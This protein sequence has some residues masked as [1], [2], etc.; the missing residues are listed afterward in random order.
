VS[1]PWSPP[2]STSEEAADTPGADPAHADLWDLY[3]RGV[4]ANDAGRPRAAQR[5]LG[6]ARARLAGREL[7][8]AGRRLLVRVRLAQALAEFELHGL[9]TAQ[10]TL[11]VAAAEATSLGDAELVALTHSQLAMARGR[12]GDLPGALTE[13][14]HAV[15]LLHRLQPRDQW[16]VH[17]NRGMVRSLLLDVAGARRDFERALAVA[18]AADLTPQ[19]YMAMHNLG[20][21]AYLAGDLPLALG[22]M[23]EADAVPVEV[24]R[25][26]PYLDR[27]RVL[28]EAGLV[29]EA[30][31]VLGRALDLCVD[32]GQWQVRGEIELELAR[33]RAALGLVAPA[34]A[35]TRRA[36]AVFRRRGAPLWAHRAHLLT[37][38]M[39]L[40]QGRSASWVATT[41]AR[42]AEQGRSAGDDALEAHASLLAARAEL[43]S[44]NPALAADH[45]ARCSSLRRG[46]S[47]S[48]RL[49][50][51]LVEADLA[52]RAG[53]TRRFRS[54]LTRA[55]RDLHLEAAR[56]ASIDLRTARSVHGTALAE[57]DLAHAATRGPAAVLACTERWRAA[58]S[59]MPAIV[60]PAD[61]ELAELL[62]QLRA[63]GR[64]VIDS[65]DP[66]PRELRAQEAR[67]RQ[68]V[69]EREWQL[70]SGVAGATPTPRRPPAMRT[71]RLTQLR[72]ALAERETDLVSFFAR[73]R[74][75]HVATLVRG[76]AGVRRVGTLAEVTGLSQ[77]V[78]ADLQALSAHGEGPLGA[79]VRSSLVKGL[80]ALDAL[81]LA[82]VRS[83][84][85]ALVVV[86]TLAVS[87]VPWGL[88]PSR[89]G[90]PTT[91]APSGTAWHTGAV[92]VDGPRVGVVVGPGLPEAVEEGREVA[93]AWHVPAPAGAG[94]TADLQAALAR[95]DLV[96]IAAHGRHEPQSPLFS[97]V[98]LT[99]G[100][101]V[102]HELVNQGTTASHVV[103]S[104]CDVGRSTLAPGDEPLGLAAAL[105]QLGVASVVAA[106]CRV[107]DDVAR[108]TMAGY[109]RWLAE[110]LEA[111][112]ALAAATDS[113][114]LLA[115]AFT[116]VG[117]P[118]RLVRSPGQ[119]QSAGSRNIAS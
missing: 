96:H 41:G 88:L 20:Y 37:L 97:S 111:S 79:A 57:L 58:T 74:E 66:N 12:S 33:A 46:A 61:E 80:A 114:D 83:S 87:L 28:L 81:L 50:L 115:G 107:P 72:S 19:T 34:R 106:V 14:D 112:E 67:L 22:L 118:T 31:A 86:P 5:A 92:V 59:R 89:R 73:G 54:V 49:Q 35:L 10:E 53:D 76:R 40:Q 68:A 64:Q 100:T 119:I 69:R 90:T 2:P 91:V 15:R 30:E 77:R 60:P 21:A 27:G 56:S 109:H 85:R 104:A 55:A 103:L 13:L 25:A 26:V 108:R 62:A 36:E 99:D 113:G 32:R 23:G 110:G 18:R 45:L 82:E 39:T 9:A 47:L 71:A 24:S 102:A 75:L 38:G 98:R 8:E 7:D 117:S 105:L 94:T 52:G 4:A 116:V 3:E 11:G 17:L 43:A 44:G 51:A 70:H 93:G 95:G 84:D 78:H 63:T 101:V 65:P 6:S 1:G 29:S 42:L 48:T 16:V